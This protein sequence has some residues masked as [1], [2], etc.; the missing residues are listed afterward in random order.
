ML[1]TIAAETFPVRQKY[2]TQKLIDKKR[3]NFA[4]RPDYAIMS[5]FVEYHE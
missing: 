4:S 5:C 1:L 2:N 3:K